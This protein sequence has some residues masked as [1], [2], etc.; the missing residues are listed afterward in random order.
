M[1]KAAFAIAPLA[2]L[3]AGCFETLSEVGKE[4]KLSPVGTGLCAEKRL[5]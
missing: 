3:L 5:D 1:M 4:P 2:F